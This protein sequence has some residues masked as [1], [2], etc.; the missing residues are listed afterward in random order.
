MNYHTNVKIV[1]LIYVMNIHII[2][3]KGFTKIKES[4]SNSF[5]FTINCTG[6]SNTQ[7]SNRAEQSRQLHK[8]QF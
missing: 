8:W 7:T 2:V 5:L 1:S 3:L 6:T 4:F